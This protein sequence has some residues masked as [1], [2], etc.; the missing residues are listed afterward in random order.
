MRDETG[1]ACTG[2][3]TFTTGAFTTGTFTT[4]AI[5]GS[6]Y[7]GIA[8]TTVFASIVV[9][10]RTM[11]GTAPETWAARSARPAGTR[12]LSDPHRETVCNPGLRYS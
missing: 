4:G 1:I 9:M 10:G 3:P 12:S 8:G 6:G 7:T 2:I 11:S 5:I